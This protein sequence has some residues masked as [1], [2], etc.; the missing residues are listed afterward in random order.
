MSQRST[1]YTVMFAA[2]VCL[3][4]SV[5]VSGA[6]VALKDKQEANKVLDRQKKVLTVAGLMKE[7]ES[8]TPEEIQKRFDDSI[9]TRLVNFDSGT[10]VDEAPNGVSPLEYDQR[11]AAKD[12]EL[13][14]A[15]PANNAKVQRMPEVATVYCVMDGKNVDQYIL[16]IQGAGLWST[17][18][19]Y[20]SIDDDANTIRG[21]TFYEH[22]ETPGLGGEV[23]NPKWKSLWPGRKAFDSKGEVAIRVKK[24]TAGPPDADPHAVDGLS[25]ATLTSNG[26]SNAL[27]FWLSDDGF[28]PYL[29]NIKSGKVKG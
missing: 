24:G 22:A 9:S 10:Y 19:G 12:P 15:A 21:I 27:A 11:K 6:A 2:G 25:G 14:E 18:Y 1:G 3:V 7:G 23:D 20:L 28:G 4:C 5:F 17:L 16:P 26:V 13:S 8:L 29:D